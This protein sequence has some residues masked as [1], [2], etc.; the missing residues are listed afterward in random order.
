MNV[1]ADRVSIRK[2]ANLYSKSEVSDDVVI[3]DND[4]VRCADRNSIKTVRLRQILIQPD[5]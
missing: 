4:I 1:I 3:G 5:I 2:V